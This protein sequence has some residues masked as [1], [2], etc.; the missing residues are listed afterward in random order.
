MRL[1]FLLIDYSF[2]NIFGKSKYNFNNRENILYKIIA[3]LKIMG[4]EKRTLMQGTS[5]LTGN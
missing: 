1:W 2:V 5:F 4:N 3:Y